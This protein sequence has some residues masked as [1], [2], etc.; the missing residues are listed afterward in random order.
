VAF[1]EPTS[2]SSKS[3]FHDVHRS[4]GVGSA[5]LNDSLHVASSE[6]NDLSSCLERRVGRNLNFIL[7]GVLVHGSTLRVNLGFLLLLDKGLIS[8]DGLLHH[9]CIFKD[10][11]Y[12]EFSLG[13]EGSEVE[14]VDGIVELCK[15]AHLDESRVESNESDGLNI[16]ESLEDFS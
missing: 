8:R 2:L 15:G 3:K 7:A 14:V 9:S 13:F 10:P 6:S 16:S 11:F 5:L 12:S 1:L 4:I